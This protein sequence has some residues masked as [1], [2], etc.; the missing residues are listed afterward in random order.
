M[1]M[2]WNSF[3]VLGGQDNLV[4]SACMG[5]SA[6]WRGGYLVRELVALG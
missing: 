5:G 6:D 3:W 2:Q 4:H 1:N